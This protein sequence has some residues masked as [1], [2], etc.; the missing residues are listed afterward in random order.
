MKFLLAAAFTILAVLAADPLDTYGYKA[1]QLLRSEDITTD[2]GIKKYVLVEGTG[3]PVKSGQ[4]INAHYDGRLAADG[5]QFDTS[6]KRG[7]PFSFKVGGGQ[8]IQGWDKGFI[9]MKKGEKAILEIASEYGY[10]VSFGDRVLL[11]ECVCL[12][13]PLPLMFSPPSILFSH[14]PMAWGPFPLRQSFSLR[15][16]WS[17]LMGVIYKKKEVGCSNPC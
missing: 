10:G 17:A 15:L 1:D 6:R 4:K 8:V 3:N 5:K 11:Y 9:G 2:G 12:H 13:C 14:R 16:S 7:Q